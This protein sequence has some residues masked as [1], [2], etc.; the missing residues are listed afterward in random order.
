M[1]METSTM[2]AI[3]VDRIR[4]DFP[5]L[6][7]TI[8]GSPLLYLD[9]ARETRNVRSISDRHRCFYEYEYE[10]TMDE[11]S[12]S[13]N[14]SNAI[15]DVRSSTANVLTSG[16]PEEIVSVRSATEAMNLVAHVFDRSQMQPGNDVAVT[17]MRVSNLSGIKHPAVESGAMAKHTISRCAW[18]PSERPSCSTTPKTNAIVFAKASVGWRKRPIQ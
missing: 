3:E 6:M 15:Q 4:Q 7:R 8:R 13:E 2:T 16:S 17:A 10:N 1:A 5:M 18:V 11:N 12:A 9:S 14:A